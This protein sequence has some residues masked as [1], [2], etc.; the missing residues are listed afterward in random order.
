MRIQPLR[1]AD[2]FGRG[3]FGSDHA[4]GWPDMTVLAGREIK[5]LSHSISH[6]TNYPLNGQSVGILDSV[7]VLE[8]TSRMMTVCPLAVTQYLVVRQAQ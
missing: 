4:N 8:S 7:E 5:G 1:S 6:P 3:G 2:L